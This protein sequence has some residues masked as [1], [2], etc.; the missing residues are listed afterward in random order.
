LFGRSN[1]PGP[2]FGIDVEGAF[3]H[4]MSL[5]HVETLLLPIQI[6]SRVEA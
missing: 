2:K 3:N 4:I 5:G 1:K 6:A